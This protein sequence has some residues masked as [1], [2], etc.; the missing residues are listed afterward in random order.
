LSAS[1]ASGILTLGLVSW[2]RVA[3]AC[4]TSWFL[5]STEIPLQVRFNKLQVLL[6]TMQRSTVP[7][8]QPAKP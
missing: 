8:M 4:L 5:L 3:L 6:S 7:S 2:R 1:F